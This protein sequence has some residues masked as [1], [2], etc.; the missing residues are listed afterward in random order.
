LKPKTMTRGRRGAL[1]LVRRLF[2]QS[3]SP[4]PRLPD[5]VRIY[6]IGDI[7]GRADLLLDTFS[8]ID[9]HRARNP[10]SRSIEIFLGDYV[11]RGPC[12]SQVIDLLAERSR[13]RETIFLK[14]NHE[15]FIFDFLKDPRL[16]DRWRECGGYETLLSYGLEPSM[17]W[18][19]EHHTVAR[20]FVEALPKTHREFLSLLRM[21]FTCG[22]YLF[23][24]AG[25]N[26]ARALDRQRAEDLLWIRDD[27]LLSEDNFGKFIIHGHTPVREP[28]IRHN[29]MNI[30]TGA[31]ATGNLTC[32]IID[33]GNLSV[34]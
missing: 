33:K 16:F 32:V 14:G 7:H 34:L 4:L 30:D 10:A 1:K 22:D 19:S 8:R 15:A 31:Y 11:D 18:S 2:L 29:R 20:S 25:V 9:L 21:Q 24:H 28:D 26:P 13:T 6:A 17:R 27:F 23:V 3:K 5:G 12:S